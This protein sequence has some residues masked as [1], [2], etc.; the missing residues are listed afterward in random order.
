MA[1]WVHLCSTVYC[2]TCLGSVITCSD[3]FIGDDHKGWPEG[4]VKTVW[5]ALTRDQTERPGAD[6]ISI[7]DTDS[8]ASNPPPPTT[9]LHTSSYSNNHT[10]VNTKESNILVQLTVKLSVKVWSS[11]SFKWI[12]L[13]LAQSARY[14]EPLPASCPD[15]DDNGVWEWWRLSSNGLHLQ[16]AAAAW[17]CTVG[18]LDPVLQCC[19]AA[20]CWP[21]WVAALYLQCPVSW[22]HYLGHQDTL[23]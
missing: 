15:N 12:T 6:T 21:D 3:K 11:D 2:A 10:A 19:S 23:Q 9:T 16:T 13:C 4:G 18:I 5:S 17:L 22:E 1:A 14:L 8:A 20:V 7:E